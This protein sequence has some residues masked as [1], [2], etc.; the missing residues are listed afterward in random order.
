[1]VILAGCSADLGECK[2]ADAKKLVY[3]P[4]GL[5]YYEGQAVVFQ[6]CAG[7]FCHAAGA[8]NAAR[9]G[10]P[11]GLNFDVV[12]LSA[13]STESDLSVLTSG[14][15]RVRD[16]ASD[17]YELV[18]SGEMPPGDAGKRDALPWKQLVNGAL[19]DY[20]LPGAGSS[21][22]KEI[23]RNWLACDAPVVASAMDAPA[24]LQPK[25]SFLGDVVA[26]AQTKIDPTFTGVYQAVLSGTCKLC[27]NPN[28]G[29]A[30]QQALDFSTADLAYSSLVDKAP[31]MGAK[32]KCSSHTGKLVIPGDCQNSLLY[33]K[34]NPAATGL[35]GDPMPLGGQPVS[36]A[37]LDAVCMWITM[38]ANK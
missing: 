34:L 18:D 35:C 20:A 16:G 22:G 19:V 27:H 4:D 32:G 30:D 12:P 7:A 26:P 37:A 31:F 36:A 38:G 25:A 11:H 17:M 13:M 29:Y 33:Q 24:A 28:G 3:T 23:L 1:M 9:R 8:K 10:V 15:K 5:P 21:Q 14:V 2:P 6:S